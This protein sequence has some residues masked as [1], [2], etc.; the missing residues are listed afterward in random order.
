[1]KSKM[2][3]ILELNVQYAS[4]LGESA[5]LA[6]LEGFERILIESLNGLSEFHRE[7]LRQFRG[8]GLVKFDLYD[9]DVTAAHHFAL[10][11]AKKI[12]VENQALNLEDRWAV[13][14]VLDFGT[15]IKPGQLVD[16]EVRSKDEADSMVHLANTLAMFQNRLI[17]R[18]CYWDAHANM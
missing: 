7:S 12:D 15:G 4:K 9:V 2:I 1:M 14:M 13:G 17:E 10:D 18:G 5:D 6:G 11:L 8:D 3:P 16:F